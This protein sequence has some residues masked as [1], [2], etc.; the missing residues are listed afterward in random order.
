MRAA[1]PQRAIEDHALIGDLHTAG[2]V[3]KDGSIDFLCLP[4]FDDGSTFASLLG[5]PENGRWRIA[6]LRPA[7]AVQRRYRG[8]TLI[9]ETEFE[10]DE[11]VV[12]LIDF[13]PIRRSRHQAPRV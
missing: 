9:L 3:A 4:D 10:N 13:M 7:H 11:G 5:T 6:P 2:L 1:E 8:N 12:R